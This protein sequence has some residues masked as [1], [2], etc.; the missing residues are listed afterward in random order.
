MDQM[1]EDFI[2]RMLEQAEMDALCD[3]QLSQG[4]VTYVALPDKFAHQSGQIY[5]MQAIFNN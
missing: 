1:S 3:V 4:A 5:H 2:L